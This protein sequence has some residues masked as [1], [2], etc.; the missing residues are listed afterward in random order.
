ML[1]YVFAFVFGFG[2][3]VP[4]L[5]SRYPKVFESD[6]G[7]WL[8]FLWHKPKFPKVDDAR[9]MAL[10]KQK[11]KKMYSFSLFWA[12]ILTALFVAIDC[13]IDINS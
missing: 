3:L 1:S 11:W 8:F 4:P 5:A 12:F 6:W 10:L 7:E 9:K 2:L 13:Y